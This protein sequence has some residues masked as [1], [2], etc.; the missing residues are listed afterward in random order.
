MLARA[1]NDREETP[2]G[3]LFNAAFELSQWR[4]FTAPWSQPSFDREAEIDALFAEMCA[5]GDWA[6]L[7]HPG[8]WLYESLATIRL[9]G[10]EAAR[11]ERIRAHHHRD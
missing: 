8:D 3:A 1:G 7:G 5:V 10:R 11:L 9:V 2:T 4:D 6:D